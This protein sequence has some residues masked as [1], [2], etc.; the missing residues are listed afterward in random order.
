MLMERHGVTERAFG[1][2]HHDQSLAIS[3]P[4]GHVKRGLMM[5]L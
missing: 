2:L 4:Y 1:V 5:A 3:G